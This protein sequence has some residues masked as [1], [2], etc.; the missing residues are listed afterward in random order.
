[1]AARL[2]VGIEFPVL[3]LSEAMAQFNLSKQEGLF[4]LI[5]L[6]GDPVGNSLLWMEIPKALFDRP[7]LVAA[8]FSKGNGDEILYH[9]PAEFADNQVFQFSPNPTGLGLDLVSPNYNT[10]TSDNQSQTAVEGGAYPGWLTSLKPVSYT[11]DQNGDFASFVVDVQAITLEAGWFVF[12]VAALQDMN[13]TAPLQKRISSLQSFKENINLDVQFAVGFGVEF[14]LRILPEVPMTGRVSD[15]RVGYFTLAYDKVGYYPASQSSPSSKISSRIDPK[16]FL[17]YKWRVEVDTDSC[18]VKK[19]VKYYI[20]PSVPKRWWDSM[21]AGIEEWNKAF[22]P[23]VLG[24]KGSTVNGKVIAASTPGSSDFPSDYSAA[25]ARYN[26]ISWAFSKGSTFALGPSDVDPRSGEILN[27]DI[28]FTHGWFKS[29]ATTFDLYG[30][31]KAHSLSHRKSSSHERFECMLD[32]QQEMN[33]LGLALTG[34]SDEIVPDAK[35]FEIVNSAIK[36]ITMHEVGHTLGLR[37]NFK[38]STAFTWEQLQND[39][40]VKQNGLST[41]VMD[42]LAVNIQQD[43]S[44]QSSYFSPTIGAYDKWVI[45]YGYSVIPGETTGDLHP[46]LSTIASE[47]NTNPWLKFGTDEDDP[48]PDGMDP[49][50]N[51]FDLSSSPLAFF[52]DRV[53]FVN[54]LRQD[55]VNRTTILGDNFNSL[56]NA[57]MSI[58]RL[59]RSAGQYAAKYLGGFEFSK[60]HRFNSVNKTVPIEL[61]CPHMQRKA[62]NFATQLLQNDSLVFP[63]PALFEYLV[64]R[65]GKHHTSIP[66]QLKIFVLCRR[67]SR[68]SR[69]LL[70]NLVCGYCGS[71]HIIAI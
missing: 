55:L 17:I 25:D 64:E 2:Q 12:P 68:A 10:R 67:M 35:M 31:D 5:T 63:P 48:S 70:W 32:K 9:L 29:Y 30:A 71:S 56:F 60:M 24:C 19:G 37:H 3:E 11:L 20:D 4:N 58:L 43:P 50:T 26:S 62:L 21:S 1:V 69:I 15:D 49:M 22:T 65:Q 16:V 44:K 36:E 28:V 8:M 51:T 42:Y 33:L 41:S 18:T 47:V 39:T 52:Q 40:F 34:S 66:F 53:E 14:S 23:A 27:A 46:S 6:G 38:A 54:L 45:R 59:I 13:P 57:E 7:F 61:P